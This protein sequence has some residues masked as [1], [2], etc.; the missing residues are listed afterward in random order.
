MDLQGLRILTTRDSMGPDHLQRMLRDAGAT[1]LAVPTIEL[2]PPDSW[3]PFD[4]EVAQ[5]ES[6]DWLLFTSVNAVL[7]TALRLQTL[8]LQLPKSLKIAVVGKKTAAQVKQQGW[9]VDLVPQT[10][11]AE[12]LIEALQAQGL[13][14]ARIL[15]P[16][17][18]VAREWLVKQLCELGA[19]VTLAPVYQN[20]PAWG[21]KQRLEDVLASGT[22]DWITFTSASTAENFKLILGGLPLQL[23]KIASIGQITTE[24][25]LVL[26]LTP[27]VTADPQTLDGL[28][29]AMVAYES[30]HSN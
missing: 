25:M 23:P 2:L 30:R 10:F 9:P 13:S 22:F 19:A 15:F 24:A 6:F 3:E 28:L 20:Q 21:S 5:L 11:Q 16:R 7:Q 17:A 12:G 27:T 1:A 26:G 4:Q 8:G 14:G 18:L 29:E